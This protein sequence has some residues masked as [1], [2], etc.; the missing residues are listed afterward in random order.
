MEQ[1]RARLT[2]L[3]D[4][5]NKAALEGICLSRNETSSQ[6]VR[7][8]IDAFLASH[9]VHFTPDADAKGPAGG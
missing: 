4:P 3:I 9:G 8:L 6:V 5:Q 2:I 7:H 1:K